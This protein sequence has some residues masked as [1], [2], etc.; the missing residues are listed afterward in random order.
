MTSVCPFCD[1]LSYSIISIS[2]WMDDLAIGSILNN[3]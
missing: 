3:E 1:D 2:P